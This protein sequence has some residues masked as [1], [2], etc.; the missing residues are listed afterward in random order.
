[1]S[2][3][4]GRE[5]QICCVAVPT[6]LRRCF[7]YY[8]QEDANEVQPGCR[9]VVPFAS[10]ER[11]GVLISSAQQSGL[12]FEKLKPL[13]RVLDPLPLF[14]SHS[15][16]LL[17]WAAD[18]YRHPIGEVFESAMPVTL[19]EGKPAE[20]VCVSRWRMDDGV[21]ER[22]LQALRRSSKQQA[23]AMLLSKCS[24]G[25]LAEQLDDVMDQW[26]VPMRKLVERGVVVCDEVPPL[27][28]GSAEPPVSV[29][30]L[31]GEQ[32]AAVLA[33]REAIGAFNVL[34]LQGIT[35]SGKTEVY[36]NAAEEVL[37][38]G[39]QVLVLVPEIGL[40]PQLLGR[41]QQRF[42]VPIA[43]LHSGLNETQRH[44]HWLLARSGYARIVIGTRSAVFTPMP[45]LGLIVVDEE[46]DP[47]FKQQEGFRYSARDVAV[48][49]AS[50]LGIPVVLGSATPSLESLHNARIG[51][52]AW[53]KLTQRTGNARLPQMRALDV[54]RKVM[55]GGVSE[56]LLRLIGRHLEQQG[57]VLLFLN[58][59]GYAPTVIC[60]DC[61]WVA[62][63]KR[64]DARMVFYQR[65]RRLRC[66][67]CG[68]ERRVEAQCPDCGSLD[69]RMLGQGTEQVEEALIAHFPQYEVIR[70]DRDSTRRKGSLDAVLER[71]R[72]G[73]GQILIGTQMLAKGHDFPNVTLVGVLDADQGLFSADFRGAE[74]MAQLLLQVAGRA[75]R[76]E[77]PGEVVVQTHHPEHPVLQAMITQGY[78]QFAETLLAER[79]HAAWPPFSALALLRAE[80]VR[81]GEAEAFL[82]HACELARAYAVEGVLLL[83]PVPAPMARRA[84]RYRAQLLLQSAR[85]S[86]L[87]R[88][89]TPWVLAL[90]ASKLGRKVRW[91]LDV[92]PQELF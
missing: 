8:M 89:L 65:E 29:P 7:D 72:D 80:S 30:P 87:H 37:A 20:V 19:R 66:H 51:R 32:Q 83:G 78:G 41:F 22:E 10:N 33:I 49:R 90:E 79:E 26:R 14:S 5:R 73:R 44:N 82:A 61:G 59:R 85:R 2:D 25:M 58:R 27:A 84:G 57:Q 21:A 36:L 55:Q 69:L 12:T 3:T 9:V 81:Q 40:T 74:R 56:P 92:D 18:Y 4:I 50:L 11:I 77:R 67:H 76:A 62:D 70:I 6:P 60:H 16:A 24:D 47:S 45:E 42:R 54:R 15:L 75:G 43:T 39:R 28:S 34:L 17:Q 63:C 68:T 1:M 91:S 88:L 86:D 52:Y 31:N 48:K 38:Q 64:C 71:V 35:G 13:R 23:L 53:L 46:H